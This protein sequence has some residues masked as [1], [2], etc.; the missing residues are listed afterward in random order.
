MKNLDL[1]VVHAWLLALFIGSGTFAYSFAGL[2][3]AVT[4]LIVAATAR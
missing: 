3:L 1:L 2:A 4:G